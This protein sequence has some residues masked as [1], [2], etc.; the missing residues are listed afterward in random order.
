MSDDS[1]KV[2]ILPGLGD[3]TSIRAL[4]CT[5]LKKYSYLYSLSKPVGSYDTA[6][7]AGCFTD[8]IAN[9]WSA[10]VV[11]YV[12]DGNMTSYSISPYSFG[13]NLITSDNTTKLDGV[14]VSLMIDD[15]PE[16]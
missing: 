7:A 9:T 12:T 8:S 4:N 5:L 14:Q 15:I 2:T 16:Q 3:F 13:Y 6:S 10:S 11:E 1:E